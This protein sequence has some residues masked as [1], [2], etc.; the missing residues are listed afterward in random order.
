M[1]G[2]FEVDTTQLRALASDLRRTARSLDSAAGKAPSPDA[3]QSSGEVAQALGMLLS[4]AHD[5]AGAIG[6]LGGGV[7]ASA[8]SY[9]ALDAGVRDR[10]DRI[11]D[12]AAPR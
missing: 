3:G 5:L 11:K 4:Q 12:T 2:G 9:D 10:F 7:D 6:A 1:N 8:D